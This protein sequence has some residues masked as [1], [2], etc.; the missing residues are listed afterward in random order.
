M[1]VLEKQA[2]DF[3]ALTKS[4]RL[5]LENIEL[6]LAEIIKDLKTVFRDVPE[7]PP[8]LAGLSEKEKQVFDLMGEGLN[9][10]EISSRLKKS[11]KTV[12][13]QRE[14]IKRKLTVKS[15]YDLEKLAEDLKA[16]P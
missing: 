3:H 12:E 14:A 8:E 4:R 16:K 15:T 5:I 1:N 9:P 6:R 13:T 11:R 2:R 7:L 10:Q